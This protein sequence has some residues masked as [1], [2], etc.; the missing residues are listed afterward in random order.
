MSIEPLVIQRSFPVAPQ[1]VYEAWT[2]PDQLKQW[3]G[4]QGFDIT[5]IQFDATVG[6]AYRIGMRSPEGETHT[7][8]GEIREIDPPKKI[9]YTWKWEGSPMEDSLV[10]VE[11]REVNSGTEMVLTHELLPSE[12][13]RQHHKQGWTSSFEKL[14]QLLQ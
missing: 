4:P 2:N 6:Q 1:V 9:V 12:E 5:E 3:F 11:F 10:T 14:A 8:V 13:S 7:A